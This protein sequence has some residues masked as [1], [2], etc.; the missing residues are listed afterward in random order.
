MAPY[1]PGLSDL[2]GFAGLLTALGLFLLLGSAGVRSAIPPEVRIVA[3][4]GALCLA[5][6][7]WGVVTPAP[8]LV[9]LIALAVGGL[10]IAAAR[11]RRMTTVAR[12]GE[13]A[14]NERKTEG[15]GT[16]HPPHHSGSIKLGGLWPAAVLSIPFWLALLPAFPS[17]VDTWLN[18]LPNAGYLFQHDMLPRHDRPPSWSF[19]PVAPYNTQFVAYAASVAAGHLVPNAMALFNL[20]LLLLAGLLLARV[21]ADNA[22]NPPWWAVA[23][24]IA[25]A[26]PLNPGFVPRTFLA[27]YGETPL[28]VTALVAVW[29]AADVLGALRR[30]GDWVRGS[31]IPLALVL[32]A[33]VN[34][35][36]SGIGLLLPIG[37]TFLALAVSDPAIGWRRGLVAG[38]TILAPA[39]ALFLLWRFY[40]VTAFD[41]GELRPRPMSE[42]NFALLPTILA[43]MVRTIVQKATF[44][45][46]LLAVLA[47]AVSF[48]RRAPR[49][50]TATL[51][52]LIGG[53]CVLYNG[54]ILFTYVAHFPPEMAVNA[55]SYF[56]YSGHLSLLVMLGLAIGLRPAAELGVTWLGTRARVAGGVAIGLVALFPLAA[57]P[58]LRFDLQAPHP[59][60]FALAPRVAA[61]LPAGARVAVLV[62]GDPFDAAGSLLRGALLYLPPRRP[63]LDF[64]TVNRADAA[65]LD[66]LHRQGVGFALLSCVP[67]T[68]PG[69]H[70]GKAAL[71]RRSEPGWTV[72][73]AWPWPAEHASARFGALLDRPTFCA[74]LTR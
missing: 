35:K 30:G 45:L 1:L 59:A 63:D 21:L 22:T 74:P 26:I 42:W 67:P 64:V 13:A 8:M 17:Q 70:A 27:G 49:S 24:G 65:T 40:A 50:D 56:R 28:A 39:L 3:G 66:A 48:W 33:L 2:T 51:L 52:A 16:S 23:C 72:I 57:I 10:I 60:V 61:H 25:L 19:L 4:W 47:M 29:L 12:A 55:H 62:P 20:A 11:G 32:V 14:S 54:F 43:S 68:L 6:T 37:L 69:D 34:T 38:A 46:F 31:A 71:L 58:L 18:L 41:A 5:L 44:Y 7:V 53:T 15:H 36:Q 73:E 9:P